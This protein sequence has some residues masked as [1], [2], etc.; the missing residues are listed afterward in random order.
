MP[1]IRKQPKRTTKKL[2]IPSLKNPFVH[3]LPVLPSLIAENLKYLEHIV[4]R[5]I[6]D[7]ICEPEESVT[8]N[9]D[10]MKEAL[11]QQEMKISGLKTL[12][13]E[14][15]KSTETRGD[16]NEE[17]EN[18]HEEASSNMLLECPVSVNDIDW[19]LYQNEPIDFF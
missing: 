4:P 8:M 7:I 5:H 14:K 10:L 12:V 16:H 19:M 9:L 6:D 18:L 11:L 3:N 2:K 1:K 17:R 13:N 15:K